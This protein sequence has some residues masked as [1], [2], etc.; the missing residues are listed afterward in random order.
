MLLEQLVLGWEK[1]KEDMQNDKKEIKLCSHM[2]WFS[3]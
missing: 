3:M 1:R 2:T